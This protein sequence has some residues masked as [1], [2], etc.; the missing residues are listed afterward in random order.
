MTILSRE[1]LALVIHIG[2]RL[3]AVCGVQFVDDLGHDL[4]AVTFDGTFNLLKVADTILGLLGVEQEQ[5]AI[6]AGAAVDQYEARIRD[7][8]PEQFV[9]V[10]PDGGAVSTLEAVEALIASWRLGDGAKVLL[11]AENQR[12]KA[13]IREVERV[14]NPNPQRGIT[15]ESEDPRKNP[16][17]REIVF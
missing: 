17:N 11:T 10:P 6:E 13:I 1:K 14:L 3:D 15:K 12:L 8:L 9:L 16:L 4:E 5:A 7:L 2:L